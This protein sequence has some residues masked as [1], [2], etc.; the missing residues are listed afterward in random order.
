MTFCSLVLPTPGDSQWES[1]PREQSEAVK[2]VPIA[3][4]VQTFWRAVGL[5]CLKHVGKKSGRNC[6]LL[7]AEG[8][9]VARF[10]MDY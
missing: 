4:G 1:I 7:V 6:R 2:S 5:L 3:M 10:Q 9:S 8:T